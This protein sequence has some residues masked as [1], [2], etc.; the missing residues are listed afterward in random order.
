MNKLDRA[1]RIAILARYAALKRVCWEI[2][3]RNEAVYKHVIAAS[4]SAELREVLEP[5]GEF[6][7]LDDPEDPG[8]HG[9]Q[10]RLAV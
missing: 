9:K 1:E 5:L 3:G 6:D 7:L 8:A 4:N 10:V 2:T